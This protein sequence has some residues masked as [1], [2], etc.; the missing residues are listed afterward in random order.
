MSLRKLAGTLRPG[1]CRRAGRRHRP[2]RGRHHAQ[3]VALRAAGARLPQVGGEVDREDR[4][5]VGRPAEVR[6]LPERPTGRP[7]EPAVRRG[8]QRHHRHRLLPARRDARPLPDDR[9]RQ[10]AVHLAVRRREPA[11]DGQAHDGAGAEISRRRAP[12]PAHSVHGDGEPDRHLFQGADQFGRRLQ[13]Q[14]DSLRLDHQQ[15]TARRHGRGADADPAA[16]IAGRARQGHRR[17]RRLPA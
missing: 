13:G 2:R 17:R 11:G 4:K 7:A 14:E 10:P 1:R 12:G 15:A 8:A 3:A 5:G 9:A 6:D 16:G